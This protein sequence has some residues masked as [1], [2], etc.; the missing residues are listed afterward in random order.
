MYLIGENSKHFPWY[1]AKDFPTNALSEGNKERL[2]NLIKNDQWT[3]DWSTVAKQTTNFMRLFFPYLSDWTARAFRRRH[4]NQISDKIY[5]AYDPSFWEDQG[6]KTIR[7][8]TA[9]QD[10]Q[11]AYIDFL[12]KSKTHR[13]YRGPQLPMCLMLDGNGTFDTPYSINFE[14]D[15]FAKSLV[16]LNKDILKSKLPLFFTNLNTLL[17]KLS[18]YKFNRQS[19]RD[20]DEIID[21]VDM[22]NKSL[23]AS[24]DTKATLYIF[25]NS[26]QEVQGGS[27]K[28]RRRSLPLEPLVFEA[29]PEIFKSLIRFI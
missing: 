21:W 19:M 24:L 27:F 15:A 22:G 29:F 3:L 18:F 17:A 7:F 25:E 2:L 26:Y 9:S 16:Y 8:A 6:G 13:E 14:N 10:Y 5:H 11:L 23:F 20:L 28:Q 12:D 4:F 1:I